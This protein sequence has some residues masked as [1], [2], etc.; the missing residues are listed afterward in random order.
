MVRW[1]I[2]GGRLLQSIDSLKDEGAVNFL[3]EAGKG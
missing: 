3:M 2:E 1:L